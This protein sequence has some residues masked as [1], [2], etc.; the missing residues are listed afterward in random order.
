MPIQSFSDKDAEKF[1]FSGSFNPK[2]GWARVQKIVKRKL[3]M[4]HYAS[5]L[6]DL[7][8]PPG[9]KLE[10]LKGNLKGFYSIRV[11]E[12]WRIVFRWTGFGAA[13][14]RVKDYH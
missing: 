4:I 8:V 7:R 13:D 1:F 3:D 12:Q 10:S 11:N 6:T 9:N 14:V 2:I 5:N